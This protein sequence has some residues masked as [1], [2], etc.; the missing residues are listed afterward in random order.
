[1]DYLSG[2]VALSLDI[3]SL[4]SS[5]NLSVIGVILRSCKALTL[6]YSRRVF[7]NVQSMIP[8]VIDMFA[9]LFCVF[10]FFTY[11]ATYL[12]AELFAKQHFFNTIGFSFFTMLQI[13]TLDGWGEIGRHVLAKQSMFSASFFILFVFIMA[14]F[15]WNILI[16]FILDL[17]RREGGQQSEM[18]NENLECKDDRPP[19]TNG[20][21]AQAV[22][23]KSMKQQLK[24]SKLIESLSLGEM[25]S[26]LIVGVYLS[27]I[28]DSM[29]QSN[30]SAITSVYSQMLHLIA[31]MTF[32]LQYVVILISKGEV[33]TLERKHGLMMTLHVLSGPIAFALDIYTL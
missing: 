25:S 33:F 32:T 19:Q 12:Y 27:L 21:K 7:S 4:V 26:K 17:L 31:G 28:V 16:G 11:L 10:F 14:Y 1:M 20:T 13:M 23:K 29:L 15:F 22:D 30:L 9:C 2:P 6:I 5:N 3:L 18:I 8:K 24:K